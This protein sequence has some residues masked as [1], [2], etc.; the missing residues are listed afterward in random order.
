MN[1]PN[2][3]H[4][5]DPSSGVLPDVLAPEHF[6]GTGEG[7]V[8]LLIATPLAEEGGWAP[9]SAVEIARSWGDAGH[10]MFLA[11]LSLLR[12]VLH[13]ILQDETKGGMADVLTGV[14]TLDKVVHLA[15]AGSFLFAGAGG[16]VEDAEAALSSE[17]WTE[18][19][20][21]LFEA[22]ASALLYVPSDIPG[23]ESLSVH[24]THVIA[25]TG[26]GESLRSIPAALS[27]RVEAVLHPSF[28]ALDFEHIGS[29]SGEGAEGDDLRGANDFVELVLEDSTGALFG[30][31]QFTDLHHLPGEDIPEEEVESVDEPELADEPEDDE[32]PRDDS[33]PTED[34]VVISD[35]PAVAPAQPPMEIVG[36][37]IELPVRSG[38]AGTVHRRYLAGIGVAALAVAIW[39]GLRGGDSPVASEPSPIAEATPEPE[40]LAPTPVGPVAAY[41][42][43]MG[44]F[45][46]PAAA[47]ELA[48]SL[49]SQG[50]EVQFIV[51]PILVNGS[52]FYR[53]LADP[54]EDVVDAQ[55]VRDA[56]ASTL[57]ELDSSDWILRETS[58]GFAFGDSPTISE[59]DV[60]ITGLA[61]MGIDAYALELDLGIGFVYRVYAGA[62]ADAGQARALATVIRDAGLGEVELQ[63]RV[64]RAGSGRPQ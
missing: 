33:G 12:P 4:A 22:E 26:A 34:A 20:G 24:A 36:D 19:F 38:G 51:V 13:E 18:V 63:P 60:T 59:A 27:E 56:L 48:T 37:A 15:K 32:S 25:L 6:V 9:S 1:D 2:K 50:G 42:W 29:F 8:T 61:S 31:P 44:S 3:G 43:A 49:S 46:N 45:S 40:A 10:R 14:N 52:T 30:E 47:R 62:Y 17:A 57:S 11:D 58:Q 35:A 5:F 39:V 28:E 64:G 53:V 54:A 21:G 23:L 16:G 55:R 41:S 7:T